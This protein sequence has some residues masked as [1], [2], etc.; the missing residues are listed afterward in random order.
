MKRSHMIVAL[1]LAGLWSAG[2]FAQTESQLRRAAAGK[3]MASEDEV[4]NFKSDVQLNEAFPALFELWKKFGGKIVIDRVGVT[5]LTTTIGMDIIRMHWKDAFEMLLRQSNYW[6]REFPD[7]IEV[8]TPDMLSQPP[9]QTEQPVTTPTLQ[10]QQMADTP[11][12]QP[13]VQSG[14]PPQ[15]GQQ[16]IVG[17][18]DSAEYYA[19]IREITISSVFFEVDRTALAQSGVSFSLFRGRGLNLGV[20]FTGSE[21]ISTPILSAAIDPTDRRLAVDVNAAI[22]MFESDQLGEE[23]ARP[24]VTVRSGNQARFQSGQDFSIKQRDFSGN[25]VEQFYSTGTIMT[26]TPTYYEFDGTEFVTL[27]YKIERSS[28]TPG[29]VTTL[30]DKVDASGTIT[31]LDGEETYVGGLY[32]TSETTVREGIPLLK[33]LPWWFFGLRYLFGYDSKNLQKKELIVLMKAEVVPMLKD[34]QAQSKKFDALQETR[35]Q[36]KQDEQQRTKKK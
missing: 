1:I 31:L 10:Q 25:T 4:V 16:S 21:K 28:A 20:Q 26:V 27:S 7:Y 13:I 32:S 11:A 23:I 29:E 14:G 34:R 5:N 6:Y 15:Q 8:V 36:M 33:D 17:K 19:S 24:Q 18:I 12:Q 22:K 3:P 35:K 30:V 2:A 9:S